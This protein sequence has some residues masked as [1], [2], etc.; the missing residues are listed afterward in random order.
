MSAAPAIRASDFP[1]SAA[2]DLPPRERWGATAN[3]LKAYSVTYS[4][5]AMT[6]EMR[7]D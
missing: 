4:E 3:S 2:D 6:C 5:Y 7:G 1:R